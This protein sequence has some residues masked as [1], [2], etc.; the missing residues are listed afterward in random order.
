MTDIP[1]DFEPTAGSGCAASYSGI[2]EVDSQGRVIGARLKVLGRNEHVDVR[3]VPYI[4][5]TQFLRELQIDQQGVIM[6]ALDDGETRLSD[7]NAEHR[8]GIHQLI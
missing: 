3:R 8:L 5:A 2:M 6:D 1:F 7:P 4:N